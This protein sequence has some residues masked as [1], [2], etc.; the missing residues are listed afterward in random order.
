VALPCR[1]EASRRSRCGSGEV[2]SLLWMV[3]CSTPVR[4]PQPDYLTECVF[5]A[6]PL[7]LTAHTWNSRS[8]REIYPRSRVFRAAPCYRGTA[9][10]ICS[11]EIAP[12][13][14]STEIYVLQ[15]GV[16]SV[17]HLEGSSTSV[18]PELDDHAAE[19]MIM[20]Y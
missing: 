1:L 17:W 6:S 8:S 12:S 14:R 10:A 13:W 16:I 7:T 9:F 2:D 5:V 11:D 20:H 4:V 15:E 3:G 19:C 18:P